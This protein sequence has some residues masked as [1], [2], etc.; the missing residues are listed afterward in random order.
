[1]K[2]IAKRVE[3]LE[4]PQGGQPRLILIADGDGFTH[5]GTGKAYSKAEAADLE[6][7]GIAQLVTFGVVYAP[8]DAR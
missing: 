6:A 1:M 2:D 3:R 8:R 7:R 5:K 4:G